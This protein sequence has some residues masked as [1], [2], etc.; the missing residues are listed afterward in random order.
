MVK[1][2]ELKAIEEEGKEIISKLI[3]AKTKTTLIKGKLQKKCKIRKKDRI[4]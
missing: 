4:I 1:I 2:I 3:K